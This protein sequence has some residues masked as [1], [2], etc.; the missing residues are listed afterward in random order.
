MEVLL[1]GLGN[2]G[3]K[4]LRKLE[5]V[6]VSIFVNDI[7]EGKAESLPYA[8]IQNIED[9][10]E[11]ITHAIVAIDPKE[12]VNV[13]KR[14]L[15][16]GIKVLLEKPPALSSE[17]FLQIKD[18]ENLYISEIELYNPCL[19]NLKDTFNSGVSIISKRLNKG[20]GYFS[21][22]WDLAWHDLYIIDYL[23]GD[24]EVTDCLGHG[25]YRKI[26]GRAG[27]CEFSIEVA[28]KY[29]GET[30]RSLKAGDYFINFTEG[31]VYKG[32][33]VVC[34]NTKD[35]LKLMVTSFLDGTY[36]GGSRE[37]A[38]RIIKELEKVNDFTLD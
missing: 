26:W 17:E 38:Y 37:R 14:L 3:L 24:I 5:E 11:S 20:I 28:W 22:L 33:S 27:S 35:K 8:F 30:N 16:K 12:H 7:N 29:E 18:Y 2:M 6:G 32:N 34:E 13:A 25:F 36:L 31:K 15:D 19:L 1:V 10:P 9:I 23:F 21:P 4:Y